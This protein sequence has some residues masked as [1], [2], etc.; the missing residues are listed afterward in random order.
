MSKNRKVIDYRPD[1]SCLT[2]GESALRAWLRKRIVESRKG[3]EVVEV[4]NETKK[5]IFEGIEDDEP[6]LVIR[7]SDVYFDSLLRNYINSLVQGKRSKFL[8]EQ[9]QGLLKRA[10]AWRAKELQP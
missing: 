9:A 4:P 10:K 5:E 7:A 2:C 1:M 6:V 3:V 8:I